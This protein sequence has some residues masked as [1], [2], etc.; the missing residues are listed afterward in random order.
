[1]GKEGMSSYAIKIFTLLMRE[2]VCVNFIFP[3]GKMARHKVDMCLEALNR[4]HL[5]ISYERLTDFCICQV[6]RIAEFEKEYIYKWNVTHSFGTKAIAEFAKTNSRKRFHEDRWLERYNITRS[7][8]CIAYQDT[9]KHPYAKFIHPEYE[10]KTKR[11][12]LSSEIGYYIC[13]ASTLLWTPFSPVCN[14]CRKVKACK[15]RTE[16]LFPEL[17]RIR[18]SEFGKKST[19]V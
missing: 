9:D 1:M 2:V 7:E 17:Y 5:E 3:R 18:V 11:R 13:G 4:E 8:L 19:K 12:M 10:D 6:A 15:E 16:R 14:K